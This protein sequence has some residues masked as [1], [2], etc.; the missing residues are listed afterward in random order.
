M[1]DYPSVTAY[2]DGSAM[3]NPGEGGVGVVL[4]FGEKTRVISEYYP[5]ATNN[6]MELMA[7][8]VALQ[9]LKVPCEVH[10]YSDSQWLVKCATG[11]YSRSSNLDLWEI[12][13]TL[14]DDHV[15]HWNWVRG[16]DGDKYNEIAHNLAYSAI[17]MKKQ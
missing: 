15:I 7:A 9:A 2:I 4:R 5:K 3:P 1:S 6:R 8:I 14:A 17:Q 10:F 12:F 16:H 11:E 13:E